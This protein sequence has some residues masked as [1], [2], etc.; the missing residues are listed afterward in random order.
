MASRP[1]CNVKARLV[2]STE[3]LACNS[4]STVCLRASLVLAETGTI[5]GDT[6]V[7]ACACPFMYSSITRWTLAPPAPNELRPARRGCSVPSISARVHGIASCRS[8]NG[9]PEKSSSAF[10]SAQC[11]VRNNC[12]LCIASKTF[13]RPAIPAAVS[14][15][16]M[17]DFTE[18]MPVTATSGSGMPRSA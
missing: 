1:V 18:P 4:R 11:N 5:A 8:R 16:P 17:L 13:N 7:C 2:K 3:A 6:F 15:W 14:A 10:G 12:P 9:L